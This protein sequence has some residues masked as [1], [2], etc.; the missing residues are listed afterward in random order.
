[1]PKPTQGRTKAFWVC[2]LGWFKVEGDEESCLGCGS[3]KRELTT[4]RQLLLPGIRSRSKAGATKEMARFKAI[5]G[6]SQ[7]IPKLWGLWYRGRGGA[8]EPVSGPTPYIGDLKQATS[9]LWSSVTS[10][11]CGNWWSITDTSFFM[12]CPHSVEG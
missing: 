10:L 4:S 6:P 11:C 8:W 12:S 5:W 7:F 3:T 9:P 2:F 1:M